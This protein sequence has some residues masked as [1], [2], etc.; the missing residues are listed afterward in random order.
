MS[1][2]IFKYSIPIDD[3]VTLKLPPGAQIISALNQRETMCLYAIVDPKG[4]NEEAH[5]V[6]IR[7]TGHPFRGNEGEFIG[8]VSF[9][10][11]GLIFHV[12]KKEQ[13]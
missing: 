9:A 13:A 2:M 8:T 11:G 3:E 10:D 12:F 7:G 1:K 4:L 6:V 5:T